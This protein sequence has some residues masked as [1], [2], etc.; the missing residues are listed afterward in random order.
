MR[1]KLLL[2]VLISMIYLYSTANATIND[3]KNYNKIVLQL[4]WKHQ[5]QFA[6]YYAALEKG[7]YK[8]A[9]FDVIIKEGSPGIS[10]IDEVLSGKANFGTSRGELLL[11]YLHGKPVV[12][13]ASIFQHSPVILLTKEN[14]N[15]KT[16]Q[17]MINKKVSLLVNDDDNAVLYAMFNNEGVT[18]DKI[19]KIPSSFDINDLITGKTDVFNAYTTNEPFILEQKGIKSVII[20]PLTYGIDFYGDCLFTSKKEIE[21]NNEN[22]KAFRKA[23]LLGWKYAMEHTDEIIDLIINKYNSHKTKEHLQ[24]EAEEIR[25]LM[26]PKL[27]EIG[28][29]NKGRWIHMADT[30]VKLKMTD[31]DYSL[32]NFIYEPNPNYDYSCLILILKIT[33][34]SLLLIAI[35]VIALV[36]FNRKLKKDVLK[37]TNQ[38]NEKYLEEIS[39]RKSLK[40]SEEKYKKL[41]DTMNEGFVIIDKKLKVIFSNK[42]MLQMLAYS[43]KEITNQFLLNFI[44][45]ENKEIFLNE[46]EK[47][48]KGINDY[49]ELTWKTKDNRNINTIIAPKVIY[50]D[51]GI[52]NGSFAV[53]T[54]ITKLKESKDTIDK[55]NKELETKITELTNSYE[56]LE[57]LNEELEES[58][59]QLEQQTIELNNAK[60]EAEK[61]NKAKSEFL[62]VM[63]HELRT[64]LNGILGLSQVILLDSELDEKKV[65]MVNTIKNCGEHLLVIIQDILDIAAIESGKNN[66]KE[67]EFNLL[68]MINSTANMLREDIKKKNIDF[69]INIPDIN[70]K[71]DKSKLRQV[72][73]NLLS[74]ANKFTSSGF[75]CLDAE[76]I[77]NE[78]QISVSD[79]GIGIPNDKLDKIFDPFVQVEEAHTRQYGG[80][81]LGLSLCKKL[82]E[83]VGG[84]IWA[85]SIEGQG[86]K[87]SFTIKIDKIYYLENESKKDYQNDLNLYK[88]NIVLAEDDDINATVISNISKYIN[89][90]LIIVKNGQEL[91][92]FLDEKADDIDLILMDIQMPVMNGKDATIM[93]RTKK[94]YNNIP[95]VAVTSF[96]S[97]KDKKECL[98][99][100]CNDYIAKPFDVKELMSKINKWI[101]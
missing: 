25:K 23:S 50:D 37:R 1:I 97:D 20:N 76:F 29:M 16:P 99:I 40:L 19:I 53:I 80:V 98:S 86:S 6:G 59:S 82:I 89:A 68:E 101:K 62:A 7:F 54:D 95:I 58:Y 71:F 56:E 69:N 51:D 15:I 73:L 100:G 91:I 52:F 38:L 49:Y 8:D 93:I 85:E 88:K 66:Y 39:I 17:D 61:A 4:V 92:N 65:K 30:Y 90:N 9:G 44:D 75:I 36:L 94:D 87:F 5:F 46:I 96:A 10:P 3:E 13:L 60:I 57:S 67:E 35:A 11:H 12:V 64:P 77:D 63:S 41:L 81:G 31:S 43:E 83:A 2:F 21:N 14:S 48:K 27:I 24:Y 47:R 55:I 78:L 79:S 18:L 32:D 70:I 34:I 74:N 72:I 84:K 28:L 45:D 42:K 33:I 26:L 22:V